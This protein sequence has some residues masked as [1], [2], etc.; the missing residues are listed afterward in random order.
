MKWRQ[1]P[2]TVIGADAELDDPSVEVTAEIEEVP[3]LPM[4]AI[5]WRA[6]SVRSPP[7]MPVAGLWSLIFTFRESM[8]ASHISVDEGMSSIRNLS[9]RL[10][11]STEEGAGR[12][13]NASSSQA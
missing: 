13:T 4:V 11:A 7:L 2:S 6:S 1:S 10:K 3:T 5:D 8:V 9:A 12:T